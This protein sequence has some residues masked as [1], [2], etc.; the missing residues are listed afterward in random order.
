MFTPGGQLDLLTFHGMRGGGKGSSPPQQA[1][2]QPVVY[3]DPV[4]GKTFVDPPR[5]IFSPPIAP[6]QSAQERLNAEISDRQAQE[7]AASDQ[8]AAQKTQDAATAETNFQGRRSQAYNDALAA[9]TRNFTE[10]GLDPNQYMASDIQPYLQSKFNSIQ[11]LDPNPAAAF[12]DATANTILNNIVS[13]KRTVANSALNKIF[14]PDYANQLIP[15]STVGNNIDSILN[16]QFDPLSS[17]LVNAQKRGTLNSQGYAAALDALN[18]SKTS[19]RSTVQGL[20]NT[21]LATD[22]GDIDAITGKARTAANALGASDTFDPTAFSSQA[23]SK[24]TSDL[25][26]FGGALRSAVGDTKFTSL[27]DLLNAGGSVQGALSPTPGNPLQGTPGQQGG[28]I[29]VDPLADQKR[30]LGNQGAF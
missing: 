27:Q 1:A 2:P 22:R 9:V 21:I 20:G 17:Q 19:A 25:S 28:T 15:D 7:K 26:N 16:E 24:A 4:N 14:T 3:T 12:P 30:G 18:K 23:T 29:P 10:Q 13:G 8:A 11:D 6:G 5:S